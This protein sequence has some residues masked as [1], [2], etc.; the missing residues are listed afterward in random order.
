MLG[1]ATALELAKRGQNVTLFEAAPNL[2]GLASAWQIG[3]VV[4]DKYYHVTLLSDTTLRSLLSELGL[5]SEIEWVQDENGFLCRRPAVFALDLRR[6]P[7]ISRLE[8]L[9]EVSFRQHDLSC[10]QDQE[11]EGS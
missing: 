7:Q 8:S 1:L 9:S 5:E 3:D 11:L 6:L 2:G 4:W 10:I